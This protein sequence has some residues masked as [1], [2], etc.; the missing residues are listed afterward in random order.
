MQMNKMP[1]S[2]EVHQMR[3]G[4]IAL[5]NQKELYPYTT[6]HHELAMIQQSPEAYVHI[7]PGVQPNVP[8]Q[9]A[10]QQGMPGQRQIPV[11]SQDQAKQLFQ[12]LNA[13]A[14]QQS[15]FPAGMPGM[16]VPQAPSAEPQLSQTASNLLNDE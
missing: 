2:P 9:Q 4:Q 5:S 16:P 13:Q 7:P 14:Q 8:I 11:M 10:M 12:E 6:D 1:R 15:G 3:S